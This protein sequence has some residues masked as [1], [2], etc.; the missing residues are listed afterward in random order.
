MTEENKSIDKINQYLESEKKNMI[1]NQ[2]SKLNRTLKLKKIRIF[3]NDYKLQNNL[4][5]SETE[6][7]NSFLETCIDQKCLNKSKDVVYNSDN[8]KIHD[9]PSLQYLPLKKKFTLRKQTN[10]KSNLFHQL[11]Y[12]SSNDFNHTNN[13]NNNNNNHNNHTNN[14]IFISSII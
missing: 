9:I 1:H 13:I 3:V 4:E 2:W 10:Y 14:N 7:L 5:D 8:G 12:S 6:T 11:P